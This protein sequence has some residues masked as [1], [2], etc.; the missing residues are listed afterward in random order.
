MSFLNTSKKLHW[1]HH[2]HKKMAYY[3]LS[4]AR[5]RRVMN[6]PKRVEEGVAPKTVAMMQPTALKGSAS[7]VRVGALNFTWN[8][9]KAA[10]PL[11]AKPAWSQEIWV[12]VQ[13]IPTGRK[14]ISAWRYPGVSK[15][16]GEI[17]GI[18]KKEYQ[19]YMSKK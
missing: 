11:K 6:S 2:A 7:G 5:V 9:K 3:R 4:E 16:R 1:T 15:V 17:A 8:A 14:I 10:A 13:D 19:S 12:M 18:M